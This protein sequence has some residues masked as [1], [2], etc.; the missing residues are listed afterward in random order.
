[1]APPLGR[2]ARMHL[3]G[4][5]V[6][7][8]SPLVAAFDGQPQVPTSRP[9]GHTVLGGGHVLHQGNSLSL[10]IWRENIGVLACNPTKVIEP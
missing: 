3:R 4:P 9:P 1:M 8:G 10:L 5:G 2:G 6:W 7:A